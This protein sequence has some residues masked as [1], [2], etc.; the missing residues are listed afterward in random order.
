MQPR[1]DGKFVND[2]YGAGATTDRARHLPRKAGTVF[3]L[4]A[5]VSPGMRQIESP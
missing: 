2:L 1:G 3:G 4:F 5:D